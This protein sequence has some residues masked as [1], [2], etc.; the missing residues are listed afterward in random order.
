[1]LEIIAAVTGVLLFKK[2]RHTAAKYFIY[3]LVYIVVIVFIG[4]Y[5]HLVRNNGFFSFLEGTLFEKN[6]WWFTIFWDIGGTVFFGWY[7]QKILNDK[8]SISILKISI[9]IFVLISLLEITFTLPKYFKTSMPIINLASALVILQCAFLYF[10]EVLRSDKILYFYK[11]LSFYITCAILILWL[12][13]T[14]LVFFEHYFRTDDMEYVNLRKNINLII[15]AFMYI[16]YT[17]GLI[18]SNPDYD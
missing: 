13:Q 9:I 10:F 15:I 4:K 18:V 14:P 1:M 5:S 3:F 12:I 6:Y 11:S 8:R 7:Y 16:S 17:I 2:Y